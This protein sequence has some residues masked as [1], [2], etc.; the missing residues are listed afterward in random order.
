MLVF[1]VFFPLISWFT[2]FSDLNFGHLKKKL[3]VLFFFFF[4]RP[5]APICFWKKSVNQVIKKKK[6]PGIKLVQTTCFFL[7]K[8]DCHVMVWEKVIIWN[9]WCKGYVPSVASTNF[10][11]NRTY[12]FIE[13]KIRLH[14]SGV[15]TH[16]TKRQ[17]KTYLNVNNEMK[18]YKLQKISPSTPLRQVWI[19]N[20]YFLFTYWW[21]LARSFQIWFLSGIGSTAII[22][23]SIRYK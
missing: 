19:P 1:K 16:N 7:N 3:I 13:Y 12:N 11:Q 10:F 6:G 22:V 15:R 23:T 20:T 2:D 8:C 5:R 18:A 4:F 14:T 21:H 17:K 9:A